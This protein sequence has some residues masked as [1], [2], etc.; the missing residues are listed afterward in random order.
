MRVCMH[1]IWPP[2]IQIHPLLVDQQFLKSLHAR[3]LVKQKG[4]TGKLVR[5]RTHY[6]DV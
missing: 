1:C 2:I 3:V 5:R 6:C 4:V